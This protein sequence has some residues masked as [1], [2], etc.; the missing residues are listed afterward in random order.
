VMEFW[1]LFCVVI[2]LQSEPILWGNIFFK[3]NLHYQEE[4]NVFLRENDNEHFLV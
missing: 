4:H 3:W 2:G 1:F